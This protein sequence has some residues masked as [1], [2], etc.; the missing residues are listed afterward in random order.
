MLSEKQIKNYYDQGYTIVN[1]I[2]NKKLTLVKQDL[3]SMIKESVK[4]NLPKYYKKNINFVLNEAMIKIESA[5]HKYLSNIYDVT[6]K[7]SSVM[8]SL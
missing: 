7:S 4:H 6:A 2:N 3:S 8:N 1:F 5:H